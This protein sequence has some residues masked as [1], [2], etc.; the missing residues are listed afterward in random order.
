M[1]PR[2]HKCN[3]SEKKKSRTSVVTFLQVYVSRYAPNET[4][5]RSLISV[6]VVQSL[7][8]VWL[9]VT[10]WMIAR[11]ASLSLTIFPSSCPLSW[12]CHPTIS[13]STALFSSCP[14]SSPASES[15]PMRWLFASGGQS[16]GAWASASV[17]PVSIQGCSPLELTSLISLLSKGLSRV[18][19]R[20][21]LQKH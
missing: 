14:Q 11:Q 3:K 16:V 8:H 7:S 9:F 19:S 6:V 15:F 2:S 12:W 5:T 13:S 21:T 17:L 1:H 4:A 18:F 10:P 20:T